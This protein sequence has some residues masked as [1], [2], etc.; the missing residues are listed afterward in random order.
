MSGVRKDGRASA[1]SS[2]L[3]TQGHRWFEGLNWAELEARRITPPRQPKESD[4]SKRIKELADTEKKTGGK[5]C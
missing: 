1:F 2:K 4:S 5:V 3:F